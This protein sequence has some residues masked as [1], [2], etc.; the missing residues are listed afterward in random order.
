MKLTVM[1]KEKEVEVDMEKLS[2]MLLTKDTL[3]EMIEMLD[4]EQIGNVIIGLYNT[5]SSES[6]AEENLSRVE[7]GLLHRIVADISNMAAWRKEQTRGLRQYSAKKEKVVEQP[8]ETAIDTNGPEELMAASHQVLEMMNN[9]TENEPSYDEVPQPETEVYEEPVTVDTA[10]EEPQECQAKKPSW[11][12]EIPG[13]C[14][15]NDNGAIKIVSNQHSADAPKIFEGCKQWIS[16]CDTYKK[17][18]AKDA[19]FDKKYREYAIDEVHKQFKEQFSRD[20][21]AVSYD[22]SKCKDDR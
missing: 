11:K 6:Y 2:Y 3:Q 16:E 10:P 21:L 4:P 19:D 7:K 13:R 20:I 5:I 17:K 14:L 9:R 15:I 22:N 18:R 12:W 1:H 8:A